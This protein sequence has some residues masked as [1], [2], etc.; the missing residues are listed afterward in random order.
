MTLAPCSAATVLWLC[1][2][3]ALAQTEVPLSPPALPTISPAQTR[4][5]V[6]ESATAPKPVINSSLSPETF[7]EVLLGEID[8]Q[9]NEPATAYSLILN[10][11]R[12]TNDAQLYQRAVEVALQSRSGEAALRAA[13]AWHQAQPTSRPANQALLQ[14]LLALNRLNDTLEPLKTTLAGATVEE[15]NLIITAIPRSFLQASDKKLALSIVEQ[16]LSDYTG[17]PSSGGAAWTTIGRMRLGNDDLVGT[18]EAAQRALTRNPST[19][20]AAFLVLEL[21]ERKQPDAEPLVVKYLEKQPTPE[22]RMGYARVLAELRRYPEAQTQLSLLTKDKADLAESWLL[23]GT[24]QLQ[25]QQNEAAEVS[26][27]RYVALAKSTPPSTDE[28]APDR[29]RTLTQAYLALAQMAED[30]KDYAGSEAWLALIDSKQEL[31]SVQ[32]RRASI[33]AHQGNLT[34]ARALLRALPDKEGSDLRGKAMAEAQLL[35][36]NKLYPEAYEVL[37]NAVNA[38]PGDVDL[39][40][41]KAMMAEKTGRLD[42]MERLLRQVI[43]LKPDYHH[44]YN[45]LGYSLADRNVRVPEAKQLILK[46]L[47]LTPGDAFIRDSLAWAEFR[48][49]NKAEALRILEAAYKAKPDAEIAAHLGEVLWSAGQRSK[50]VAMWK[51]GQRIDREN[52]TLIE[53]LKRLRAPL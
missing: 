46:A 40:Y 15:R 45:A 23:L 28:N 4:E 2:S 9:S 32:S 39:I 27:K 20:G 7:Y 16:A 51:E 29:S 10:A 30:R 48:L 26:L 13:K 34:E 8:L 6:A 31:V 5:P 14:I 25:E 41:E 35:R 11:A 22:I 42:E 3:S 1:L 18:L 44:A 33:L 19:P 49:G 47:E 37:S 24:L 52:G 50:A 17:L 43:E 21:M 38:I 12:R 36:D 53:T